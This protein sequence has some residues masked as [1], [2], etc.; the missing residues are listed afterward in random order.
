MDVWAAEQ[1]LSKTSADWAEFSNEL[2]KILMRL[3]DFGVPFCLQSPDFSMN[4][5]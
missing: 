4:N 1:L 2:D 5:E 3:A